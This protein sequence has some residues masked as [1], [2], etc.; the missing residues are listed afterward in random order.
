MLVVCSINSALFYEICC[1]CSQSF[2]ACPFHSHPLSPSLCAL[3]RISFSIRRSPRVFFKMH[4]THFVIVRKFEMSLQLSTFTTLWLSTDMCCTCGNPREE[5]RR[6]QMSCSSLISSCKIRWPRAPSLLLP[7]QA[8]RIRNMYIVYII[9]RYICSMY[10]LLIYLCTCPTA[11]HSKSITCG[12]EQSQQAKKPDKLKT[13]NIS[14]VC[15]GFFFFF[16]CCC[17]GW[18]TL[19]YS[20]DCFSLF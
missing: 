19:R 18:S 14:V 7:S 12:T 11:S 15:F 17:C 1:N 3:F 9:Y 5:V 8:G 4:L 6:G 13:L 20:F 2:Y 16:F 10:L